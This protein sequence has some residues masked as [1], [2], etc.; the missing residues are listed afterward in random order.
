MKV[1]DKCLYAFDGKDCDNTGKD[2]ERRTRNNTRAKARRAE[3]T[4]A[5]GKYVKPDGW[6]LGGQ[7]IEG[8]DF[9]ALRLTTNSGGPIT[10]LAVRIEVTGRTLRTMHGTLA[11]RVRVIFVGDGEPDSFCGGIMGVE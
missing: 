2:C 7:L 4:P 1:C 5:V 10:D 9:S 8:D 11:V 3:V 6:V